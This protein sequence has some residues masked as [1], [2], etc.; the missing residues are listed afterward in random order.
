MKG[1]G[2]MEVVIKAKANGDFTVESSSRE[3]YRVLV[4]LKA[5]V[6]AVEQAVN[7]KQ[8]RLLLPASHHDSFTR[9]G[10]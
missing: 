5:A 3:T 1:P 2:D 6:K 7:R 9:N 8:G 4:V 10:E